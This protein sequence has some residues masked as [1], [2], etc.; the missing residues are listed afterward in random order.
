MPPAVA[1]QRARQLFDLV[2][3]RLCCPAS[4]P[5]PC[6]PFLYPDDGCWARAHE[7]CRLMI[8]AGAQPEKVWIYGT[9]P[10][11][12][13]LKVSSQN[14]PNCLVQLELARRTDAPGQHRQRC[15]D[16]GYRSVTLPRPR[17]PGHLGGR[18]GR[19]EPDPRAIE[20]GDLYPDTGRWI[21]D[22]RSPDLRADQPDPYDIP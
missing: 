20:R 14:K 5:A 3:S 18:A 7:M 8:A 16:V 17:V 15:R 13:P 19:P 10:P 4:A 9:P 22:H 1:P 6:I 11:F 21:H 2:N 12:L